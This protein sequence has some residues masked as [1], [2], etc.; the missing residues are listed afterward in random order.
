MVENPMVVVPTDVDIEEILEFGYAFSE[1]QASSDAVI[2]L[3]FEE[4]KPF[5]FREGLMP[6]QEDHL[7][8]ILALVTK[9]GRFPIPGEEPKPQVPEE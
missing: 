4:V 3:R 8:R 5:L 1:R 9:E 6:E 7:N 2:Y